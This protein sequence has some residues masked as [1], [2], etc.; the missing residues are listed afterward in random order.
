MSGAGGLRRPRW[1]TT[2]GAAGLLLAALVRP[3]LAQS[4]T[5]AAPAA[6]PAAVPAPAPAARQPADPALEQAPYRTPPGIRW[7]KWGAALVAVAATGIGVHQ[8]NAGNNAYADLV[9]YCANV[10]CTIGPDGHY[11]DGFAEA[12]YRQ[13]VRDDRSAR[14]WIVAG[15]LAA[16]GSAVLFV[17][18]LKHQS[19]PP[20]IPY[21]GLLVESGLGETRIG[22]RVPVRILT[23]R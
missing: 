14:V 10:T 2:V 18:E 16:V 9:H 5:A 11:E 6:P 17:L 21:S 22:W 7:G 4:D 8:H 20:N 15:Q 3:A 19:E 1:A 23:G 13:V 12:T